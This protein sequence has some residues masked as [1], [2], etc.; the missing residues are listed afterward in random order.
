MILAYLVYVGIGD[1]EQMPGKVM[2]AAL[3]TPRG[4]E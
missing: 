2:E 4:K 3:D 1:G